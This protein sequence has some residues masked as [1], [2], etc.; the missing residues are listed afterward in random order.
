MLNL[1]DFNWVLEEHGPSALKLKIYTAPHMAK[2][3]LRVLPKSWKGRVHNGRCVR[4]RGGY[5][6]LAFFRAL[7]THPHLTEA[8]RAY[9]QTYRGR[10]SRT[11]PMRVAAVKQV[12]RFLR[13]GPDG[14]RPEASADTA[15]SL[16]DSSAQT[17]LPGVGA[18]GQA[19][20]Q[21]TVTHDVSDAG[22]SAPQA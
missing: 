12:M 4:V 11:Y 9:V 1:T 10:G 14:N 16:L 17:P 20:G 21:P 15:G 18:A 22:L 13:E 19:L 8:I 7:G 5:A 3:L 2:E 6:I